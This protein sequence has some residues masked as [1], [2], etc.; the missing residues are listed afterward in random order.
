MV[1]QA[2]G[3][4]GPPLLKNIGPIELYRGRL[5][6]ISSHISSILWK[7]IRILNLMVRFKGVGEKKNLKDMSYF[8]NFKL[9]EDVVS[10]GILK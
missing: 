6:N 9:F 2:H 3:T 4:S 1:K 8:Y 10:K 7:M 5:M